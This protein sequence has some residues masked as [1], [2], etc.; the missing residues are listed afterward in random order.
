MVSGRDD[1]LNRLKERISR[2]CKGPV[3][4]ALLSPT[5]AEVM[6]NPDGKIWIWDLKRGIYDSGYIMPE[7]QAI[8]MLQTSAAMLETTINEKSPILEGEFPLDG[9]RLEGIVYPIVQSA[10]FSIRKAASQV[11]TLDNYRESGIIPTGPLRGPLHGREEHRVWPHAIDCIRAAIGE[12]KNILVVG[13]TGSGK[14]TFINACFHELSV[15]C[16]DDRVIAIEDTREVQMPVLNK[17]L[18]RSSEDVPMDRLLK[19]SLRLN[20]TRI[21]VGE[22]RGR[23]AFTL[24]KAWGTGHP[25]GLC[26]VHAT[27]AAEG[28]DIFTARCFEHPDGKNLSMDMMGRMIAAV[29]DYVI[30]IEQTGGTTGRLITEICEVKGYIGGKFSVGLINIEENCDAQAA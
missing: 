4:D 14:T 6:R 19:A 1:Q 5:V 12:R 30:V 29:V 11:F 20:P 21:V 28:L 26:T 15:Q 8:S 16:P 17:V 7:S 18:M 13:G 25:G 22:V 9:S 24:V 23:E 10:T 27:S 3:L 2:E